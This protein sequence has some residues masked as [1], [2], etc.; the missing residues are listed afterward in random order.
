VW[1]NQLLG[2]YIKYGDFLS[3]PIPFTAS[4]L[5]KDIQ[6][7]KPII[8]VGACLRVSQFSSSSIWTSNWVPTIPNFKPRPKYL[9]NRNFPSLQIMDLI[10]L[11][12]L[13][14]K[15]SSIH[16]LFDSILANEILKIRISTDPGSQFIWTPSTSRRFTTSSVYSLIIASTSNPPSSSVSSLFWKLNLNDRLKL[17]LWK[18]AWNILPTKACLG[19][20]FPISDTRYPLCKVANDSLSLLFFECFFA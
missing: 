9:L 13:S 1:V 2:K 11:V 17:F 19:Q 14:W 8:Y 5:W 10:D 4:W 16:A 18:I 6:K 7:I 20:L 15:A 3:S 12:C